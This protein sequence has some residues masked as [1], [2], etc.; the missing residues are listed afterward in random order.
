MIE[1]LSSISI[2]VNENIY[3]KNPETS[4]LGKK[5]IAESIELIED[6]GFE[7]FTF[8]K[9]S[10]KINS[11]EASVY[12]YFE[13]KHKLLLYITSWYWGWLDYVL[14]FSTV[15][16]KS[17]YE[18]LERAI[19]ILTSEVKNDGFFEH[20]NP[21]KLD[22]II[23]SE[24]SKA[25]LVKEVDSENKEGAYKGYKQLVGRVSEIILEINPKYNYPNMLVSTVI[26]GVHHQRYFAEHLPRLTNSVKGEDSISKF[27]L[28]MVLK[29]IKEN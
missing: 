16:I 17:P 10:E 24:S 4:V 9:L 12:R 29:T 11:T 6:I 21:I 7:N 13:N 28:E 25:Y 27:Y 3:L 14:F 19:N 5:I 22:R 8:K 2:K 18:K 15:N 23:I 1:L 26:E 20:I